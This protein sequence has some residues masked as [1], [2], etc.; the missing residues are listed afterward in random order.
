MIARMQIEE[1]KA[2]VAYN[3]LILGPSKHSVVEGNSGDGLKQTKL[4][5]TIVTQVAPK[6]SQD[7]FKSDEVD[8]K[9]EEDAS[10]HDIDAE[11]NNEEIGND[12]DRQSQ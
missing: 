7:T 4:Q 12:Y 1:E 6:V 10:D 3:G 9:K 2:N 8:I 11:M 5:A